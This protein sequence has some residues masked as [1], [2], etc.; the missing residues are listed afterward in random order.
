MPK[1]S[2]TELF[3]SSGGNFIKKKTQI[4]MQEVCILF[5]VYVSHYWF[6]KYFFLISYH[7]H[8]ILSYFL[9]IFLQ[10][11]EHFHWHRKIYLSN[12]SSF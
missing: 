7:L 8:I 2:K 12:F 5:T 4:Y 6:I 10:Q 1:L 11:A 3:S 9:G